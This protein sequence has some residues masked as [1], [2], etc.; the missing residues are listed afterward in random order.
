M[1]GNL[2][3][4]KTFPD[5]EKKTKTPYRHFLFL[6][7]FSPQVSVGG[8]DVRT[9]RFWCPSGQQLGVRALTFC[10]FL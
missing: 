1:C 10:R 9:R 5:E 8:L 2:T 7:L 4:H 3:Q 6:L